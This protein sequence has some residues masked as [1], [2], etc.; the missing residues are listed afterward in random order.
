VFVQL[1]CRSNYF[2]SV[3]QTVLLGL[4][5][6]LSLTVAGKLVFTRLMC[7]GFSTALEVTQRLISRVSN[8]C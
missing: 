4:Q 5:V 2:A 1:S 6:K 7:N 8:N 3:T